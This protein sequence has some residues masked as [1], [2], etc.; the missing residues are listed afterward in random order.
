MNYLICD[1]SARRFAQDDAFM[2]GM[3]N[4]LVDSKKHGKIKK[5]T[6]SQDDA[7]LEGLKKSGRI[8]RQGKIEKVIS[9]RDDKRE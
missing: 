1:G 6:S 2:E 8:Q 7:F 3:E 5:V 4:H 9:V